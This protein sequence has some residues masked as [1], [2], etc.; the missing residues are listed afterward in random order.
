[1]AVT[2]GYLPLPA[3]LDFS[4]RSVLQTF[5]QTETNGTEV[6]VVWGFLNRPCESRIYP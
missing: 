3:Q 4:A 5:R 6:L 1:M 2:A